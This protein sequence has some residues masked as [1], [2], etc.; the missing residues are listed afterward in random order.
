MEALSLAMGDAA[1]QT[2]LPQICGGPMALY[3]ILC[4]VQGETLFLLHTLVSNPGIPLVLA[5]LAARIGLK[6]SLWSIRMASDVTD[7]DILTVW[8]CS[9]SPLPFLLG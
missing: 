1:I 7:S 5:V 2:W 4:M 9:R 3:M 6:D 8:S